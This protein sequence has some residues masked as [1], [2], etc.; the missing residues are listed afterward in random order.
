MID[1]IASIRVRPGRRDEFLA[2]FQAN[3][4]KVL[5]EDGC[6]RYS[7]TV[8][9]DSG[10]GA[11]QLD[12][13]IVTIVE[14]WESVAALHAHL[15]APHMAAYRETVKDLVEGTTLKVLQAA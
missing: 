13:N 9:A 1:V 6:L 11:Q 15:K 5:A 10:L 14:Q 3:V 8:D 4:P 7:P 2:K 12:E